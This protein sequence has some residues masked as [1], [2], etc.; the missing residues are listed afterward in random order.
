MNQGDISEKTTESARG[1][2]P[3][4][5]Y[6]TALALVFA[7]ALIATARFA[8]LLQ[9]AKPAELE[10]DLPPEP[11]TV[12]ITVSRRGDKVIA[13]CAVVGGGGS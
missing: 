4:V 9:P 7:V 2:G 6:T 5:L 8:P 1:A 12:A 13:Q 10:C 11:N 3:S